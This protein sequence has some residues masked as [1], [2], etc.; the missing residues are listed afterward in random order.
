MAA[1]RLFGG[2]YKNLGWL[3]GGFNRAGDDD[4]SGVEARCNNR[5]CI[6]LFPSIAHF[7]RS[8]GQE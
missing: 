4:F 1:T 8:C 5:G 2:G 6:I 7:L 3:A